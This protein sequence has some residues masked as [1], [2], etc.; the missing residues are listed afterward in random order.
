MKVAFASNMLNPGGGSIFVPFVRDQV[1]GLRRLGV[2]V[3]EIPIFS[4]SPLGLRRSNRSIRCAL[5]KGGCDLVHVHYGSLGGLWGVLSCGHNPS[6]ITFHGSDL[7]GFGRLQWGR[8]LKSLHLAAGVGLSHLAAV[9]ATEIVAVSERVRGGLARGKD[10]A[11]AH[12]IPCGV[13]FEIF[14][15]GNKRVARDALGLSYDKNL[16]LFVDPQRPDKRFQLAVE[17]VGIAKAGI[18]NL[19]ILPVSGVEHTLIPTYLRACDVLLLTSLS[20]GSPVVTKEALACN[21][22]VVSVDVGDM[23]D[24]LRDVEGCDVT[25][26][27]PDELAKGLVAALSVGDACNG[28]ELRGYYSN[29]EVCGRLLG[30]YELVLERCHQGAGP[31]IHMGSC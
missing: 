19:A 26:A 15:P 31:R 9:S 7:L 11:R 1:S 10:R 20:E 25:C 8:P 16:V 27:A 13:D 21:L 23:R 3:I 5:D 24:Q 6:V 12:I 30:I 29:R 17:A 18:P 14:K 2:G 28:R 4:R 22:P